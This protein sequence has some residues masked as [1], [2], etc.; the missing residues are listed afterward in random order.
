MKLLYHLDNIMIKF[1]AIGIVFSFIALFAPNAFPSPVPIDFSNESEMAG[2]YASAQYNIGF[3]RFSPISAKY[4][5]DE[6][7]E[8]ELTLF[9]L[10][11][12]TETI[13][14][15]KAGD[16]KKGYS[17]VYNRNYTGFSGAIGYSGGGLRVELEGSFT[18]FDVDKQKYKNPDGHRY[19]ALSK[20]SEIQNGS[21]GGNSNN[22]GYVVMK[23]EGFNAI[24]LMFN[25]CYDMI[26]GNSSLVPNAC[27]GIGQGIIRFLG[28]TN[29]HTLFKA[30]LGL[31]FLISPKTILFANGYYVKAKDN[32]FTNLSVQYP[33]EIS[34]APK[35]IDPIVYFNAD[36][37]GCE[38]GLRF[39]L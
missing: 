3:P 35:H 14:L 7:S 9:S 19:F 4:K 8:K 29:I 15:K 36:N 32:A 30:K 33:V 10:K 37:Y 11:E 38:V 13:D 1:S 21:S 27:I 2:F 26:I 6:K 12:E 34:A 17:P 24:S 28:G 20:D 25:A 18:R 23:N 5:T 22:K 39:I 16:F 31:G